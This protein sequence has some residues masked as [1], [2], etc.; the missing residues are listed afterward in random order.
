MVL[1]DKPLVLVK[2]IAQAS[3]GF[4][5][6]E[7]SGWRIENDAEDS[8]RNGIGIWKSSK[9]GGVGPFMTESNISGVG[10]WTIHITYRVEEA[11]FDGITYTAIAKTNRSSWSIL[12]DRMVPSEERAVLKQSSMLQIAG[13]MKRESKK[14]CTLHVRAHR[15]SHDEARKVRHPIETNSL[16]ALRNIMSFHN[17]V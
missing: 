14:S 1:L 10:F 17:K 5:C 12:I 7:L 4:S 13:S 2:G 8:I 3:S 9:A 11:P 6:G 16:L 15:I